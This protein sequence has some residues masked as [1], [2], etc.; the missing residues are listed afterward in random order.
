MKSSMSGV[1]SDEWNE[2]NPIPNTIPNTN[3]EH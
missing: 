2:W 1:E 3:T